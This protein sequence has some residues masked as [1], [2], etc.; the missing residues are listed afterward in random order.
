MEKSTELLATTPA[1]LFVIPFISINGGG[2]GCSAKEGLLN[3]GAIPSKTK[4]RR[5]SLPDYH[6]RG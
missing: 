6:A 1:N 5:Q 3:W 2:D 4:K